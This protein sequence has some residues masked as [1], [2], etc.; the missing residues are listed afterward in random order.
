MVAWE[1]TTA[2]ALRTVTHLDS[3]FP[4][5]LL[6]N[7]KLRAILYCSRRLKGLRAYKMSGDQGEYILRCCGIL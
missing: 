4:L 7:L 6:L 5:T 2:W 1:F 3:A